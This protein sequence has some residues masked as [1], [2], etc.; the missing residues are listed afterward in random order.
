[1]K[2]LSTVFLKPVGSV[3]VQFSNLIVTQFDQ[4]YTL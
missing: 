2:A 3:E 4:H 1:M